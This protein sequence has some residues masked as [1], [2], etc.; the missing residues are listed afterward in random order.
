MRHLGEV[1][2]LHLPGARR[3]EKRLAEVTVFTP[4]RKVITCRH[5]QVRASH[6]LEQRIA[7]AAKGELLELHGWVTDHAAGDVGV[8]TRGP[9]GRMAA[10]AEACLRKHH[11]PFGQAWP[12]AERVVGGASEGATEGSGRSSSGHR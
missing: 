10:V 12:E 3:G 9:A 7:I 6:R 4:I 11:A 2:K 8:L 5:D 1:D